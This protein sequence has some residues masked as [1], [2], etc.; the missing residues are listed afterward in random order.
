MGSQRNPSPSLR[1][2]AALP[3][4]TNDRPPQRTTRTQSGREEDAPRFVP[5]GRVHQ[6]AA[7]CADF[8]AA[9]ICDFYKKLFFGGGLP[10]S[11]SSEKD[12]ESWAEKCR[13]RLLAPQEFTRLASKW[14]NSREDRRGRDSLASIR[15]DED[16]STFWIR[17]PLQARE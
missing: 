1:H 8:L 14:R 12:F 7:N 2:S 3:H 15:E 4:L 10:E 5:T 16:E 6:G 13:H 9:S 11:K 17:Q